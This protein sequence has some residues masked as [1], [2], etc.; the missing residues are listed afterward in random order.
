MLLHMNPKKTYITPDGARKLQAELDDLWKV[1]RPKITKAV[2]EAAAMGDRS[3]NAE[4]IYGK[5][6]MREI[7]R[8]VRWLRKRLDSITIVEQKPGDQNK[9]FFGA[10]VKLLNDQNKEEVYQIVGTDDLDI[11]KN[12]ITFASPM[13]RALKGREKGEEIDISL[14]AGNRKVKVIEIS[15]DPME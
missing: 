3:E 10:Y 2:S 7:D 6:K 9:I 13:G 1:Q 4:Y 15:Y 11:Q 12:L 8:R 5:K 14:P